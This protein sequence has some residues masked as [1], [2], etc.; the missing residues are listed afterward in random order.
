LLS[1][2]DEP[3]A[4]AIAAAT[5][6]T[7]GADTVLE[8]RFVASPPNDD[9]AV[10]LVRDTRSA[11]IALI[12]WNDSSREHARLRVYSQ[13]TRAWTAR[14]LEFAARDPAE[15]KGRAI[16]FNLASMLPEEALVAQSP[17][18]PAPPAAQPPA[19]EPPA[20]TPPAA[21]AAPIATREATP[22]MEAKPGAPAAVPPTRATPPTSPPWALAVDLA[23]QGVVAL[24]GEG[25]SIG[26]ALGAEY[27]LGEHFALCLGAALRIGHVEALEA[28]MVAIDL[29][30]GLAWRTG[31]LD[32]GRRWG[33]QVQLAGFARLQSLRREAERSETHESHGRWVPGAAV[34]VE[35]TYALTPDIALLA[36]TRLNAVLGQTDVFLRNREVAEFAPIELGL[37]LGART[38]F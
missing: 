37:G 28:R 38:Y 5:R 9:A 31:D 4:A 20:T 13:A 3:R 32:A 36:N 19:I 34:G 22:A 16:G 8:L 2:G 14:D 33:L 11:A 27:R 10:A 21:P 15:E 25:T 23:A 30:P 24:S 12:T 7:I 17:V 35:L 1:P 26:G 6:A 18:V 29:G